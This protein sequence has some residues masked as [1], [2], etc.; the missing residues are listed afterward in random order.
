MVQG[1][2]DWS[3]RDFSA[4]IKASERHGRADRASIAREMESKSPKDVE[5]YAAV[6]WER[7]TELTNADQ[8]IG[9]QWWR[10][11]SHVHTKEFAMEA[12]H[13]ISTCVQ[14]FDFLLS[15]SSLMIG[16]CPISLTLLWVRQQGSAR[17]TN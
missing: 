10:K 2:S 12:M 8:I 15:S 11:G 4:F 16:T 5:A 17:G 1:F 13:L 7:Y 14:Y 3:K 6:F 9:A